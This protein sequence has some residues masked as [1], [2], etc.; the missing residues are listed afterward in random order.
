MS[1]HEH[2]AEADAAPIRAAVVTVSSTRT[3]ADDVSGTIIA[4]ALAMAEV[5]QVARRIVDDDVT[6]IQVALQQL[7]DD[8]TDLVVLTGGT[9]LTP[10]DV[11]PEA[12]EPMF[13]RSIP[14][15]GELFRMLSF[16]QVGAAAMLSRAT[17]GMVGATAVFALPGSRRAC[18]LAMERL[19]LPEMRHLVHLAHKREGVRRGHGWQAALKAVGVTLQR[20]ASEPLPEAVQAVPALVDALQ[21]AGERAVIEIGTWRYSVWGFPDLRRPA[22]KVLAISAGGSLAEVVALHRF[23]VEVGT[24]VRGEGGWLV[25]RDRPLAEVC[26]AI[27]GEVAPASGSLFAVGDGR[28]YIEREGRVVQWDG[29]ELVDLGP[30]RTA[31]LT[32]VQEWTS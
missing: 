31:L 32:L 14:G 21:Q 11:T 6:E 28:V 19:I 26:D 12:V 9:G 18:Q 23:P 15:F 5:H 24:C 1:A 17:A 25:S 20:D 10:R 8:G 4:G 16:Q 2:R 13:N 27:T 30:V 3:E 29:R 22:S 7:V